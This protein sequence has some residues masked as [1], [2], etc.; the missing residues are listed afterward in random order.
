M[1][2][3]YPDTLVAGIV[4]PDSIECKNVHGDTLVVHEKSK[5]RVK[6]INEAILPSRFSI[7]TAELP[8]RTP[9]V[10]DAIPPE[11]LKP[12]H[13]IEWDG[14][15]LVPVPNS[16]ITLDDGSNPGDRF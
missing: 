8:P 13:H 1:E 7:A 5:I 2:C 3:T 15:M 10:G 12:F 11:L 4:F 16:A 9:V 14:E 6:S